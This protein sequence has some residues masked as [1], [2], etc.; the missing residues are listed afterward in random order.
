LPQVQSGTAGTRTS[1][2]SAPSVIPDPAIRMRAVAADVSASLEFFSSRFGPP[3][4]K[5]LTVAPIP[6]PF[7]QG[8]PGLVY[9]STLS[10]LDPA[11]FP[12]ALRDASH[13]LFFSDL[14]QAHEVA[15]QWWGNVVISGAYQDEWMLEALA[16]YSAM[17]WL[18]KKKGAKAVEGVLDGYREHLIQKDPQGQTI[19]SAGPIVWGTR[20]D[21]TGV[22]DAWRAITYEK[23]AWIMHMLRSRLGDERFLK[24]LAELRRRYEFKVVSTDDF[25]S[26]A[27]EFAPP[28]TAPGAID[29][30]F[31][32]WVYST[33]IPSLKLKY[34]VT[35]AAP[36]VKLTGTVTQ[37]GVD[38]DF[39][40]DAP[41]EIQFAKGAAQTIWVRTSSEPTSFN[42]MLKQTPQH[43]AVSNGVLASRK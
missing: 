16:S 8:F 10:Y 7:G 37:S 34:T 11:Q 28:K 30:L 3:A 43:V 25:R 6:A 19:E 32:N 15:H 38:D 31:E 21:S 17:L 22:P 9:L 5:T 20:L 24:M 14:M 23:G 33:G 26:L 29:T 18:E 12:S 35:G 42:A 39:S 27:K 1:A 4:L 13:Q 41:V 40:I 36:S 2:L